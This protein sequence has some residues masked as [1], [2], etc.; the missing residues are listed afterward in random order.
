MPP[1]DVAE[2]A[3]PTAVVHKPLPHDSARLH[4]QGAAT[5][6]DDIGEPAGTLHIAI[7]MA[8]QASGRLRS[9]DLD[10]VR[11]APGVV[12]VLTRRR[13]SRQERHRA[14]V[15][16]RALVRRSTRSC[17][18]GRLCSPSSRA[19]ATRRAGRRGS[20]GSTSRRRR[21][22]SRSPMRSA[23][24]RAFR[25]TTPSGAATRPPR[26]TGPGAGSRASFR[27]AAR[28]I[29]ISKARPRSPFPAKA[30]K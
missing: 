19:R 7:G 8:N 25:T 18:T 13:Y 15:R 4:V 2:L 21:R 1:N 11:G 6:V 17:S 29:S 20:P 3:S 5:Y 30:T 12:A 23:P 24:A 27:S 26:S 28:S 9:L 16:R 10:A 14:G 22:R